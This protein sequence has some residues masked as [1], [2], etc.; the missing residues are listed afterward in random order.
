MGI[1]TVSG[2]F[3]SQNGFQELVNG[4]WSPIQTNLNLTTTGTS[5]PATL[6]GN[7]LNVPNYGINLTTTGTSGPA[8]LAG[9]TLNVPQ[10][11]S[12]LSLTTTGTSGPATLVGSNLNIPNYATG[13]GGGSVTVIPFTPGIPNQYTLPLFTGVGQTAQFFWPFHANTGVESL[14]LIAP[15]VPG[16]YAT[17]LISVF[18]EYDG[19]YQNSQIS[20]DVVADTNICNSLI[21]V[22]YGG[23]FNASPTLIAIYNLIV[24][25]TVWGVG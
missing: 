12:Q 8:T 1:S 16:T 13:G 18:V 19:N 25:N 21:T 3:R 23:I 15:A 2:P 24:V 11:Q 10:Y 6:V 22:S 9:N 4:E 17:F 14:E 20:S 7:N 5:G